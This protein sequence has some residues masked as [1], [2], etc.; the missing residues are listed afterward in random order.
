MK[1]TLSLILALVML[2]ALMAGCGSEPAAPAA[3]AEPAP[4]VDPAAPTE[5]EGP[6]EPE[7]PAEPE[8]AEVDL[9]ILYDRFHCSEKRCF[10]ILSIRS[11]ASK[12]SPFPSTSA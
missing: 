2:L 11:C 10:S 8:P 12:K 9:A 3:P 1:K 5:P 7:A 4:T 6:A